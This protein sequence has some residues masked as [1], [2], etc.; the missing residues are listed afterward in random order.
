MSLV[1]EI[2][3]L[4]QQFEDESIKLNCC[5]QLVCLILKCVLNMNEEENQLLEG[6]FNILPFV[7]TNDLEVYLI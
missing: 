3:L 7:Q 1:N 6:S 2:L 4:Q 5:N